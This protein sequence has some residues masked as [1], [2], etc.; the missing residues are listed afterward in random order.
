[1]KEKQEEIFPEAAKQCLTEFVGNCRA[2][3]TPCA[4]ANR[5]LACFQ[6]AIKKINCVMQDGS[7]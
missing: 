2:S 1:L 3:S 4:M 6:F 5:F 7:N